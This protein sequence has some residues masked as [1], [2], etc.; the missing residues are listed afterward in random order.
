MGVAIESIHLMNFTRLRISAIVAGAKTAHVNKIKSAGARMQHE[1]TTSHVKDNPRTG[2]ESEV[3]GVLEALLSKADVAIN[4]DRP[5][6]IQVHDKD[7]YKRVLLSWSL[8]FGEAYMDGEWDCVQLDEL[9]TR[10]LR[11]DIDSAATGFAKIRLIGENL[12]QR[13]F[14][15]QSKNRA[16]QVGEQHY[17]VGNDVFEAMLDSRMTYT[18][19][20]WENATDLRASAS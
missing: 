18:C 7:V 3:P 16:F 14:N 9:L 17:D 6:D 1:R 2:R 15:L 19:G 12:R 5:W 20:Y 8:G 10:L 13:L 11:M 4:G